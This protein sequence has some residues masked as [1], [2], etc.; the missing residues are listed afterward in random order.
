MH[1]PFPVRKRPASP[2]AAIPPNACRSPRKEMACRVVR[3]P[4]RL[5]AGCARL[6]GRVHCGYR[7]PLFWRLKGSV[8]GG[9]GNVAGEVSGFQLQNTRWTAGLGLRFLL[10]EAEQVHVRLDYGF[11]AGSSGFYLTVGEA[12]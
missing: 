11:A 2:P 8:F 7:F 3:L 6:P 4:E 10:L 9:L 1:C 5:V 12:F